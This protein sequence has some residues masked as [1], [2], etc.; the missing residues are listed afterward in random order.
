MCVSAIKTDSLLRPD[1]VGA[2]GGY[3]SGI[4]L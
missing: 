3:S 4:S 2:E 1:F